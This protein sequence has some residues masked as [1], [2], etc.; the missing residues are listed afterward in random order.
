MTVV[1]IPLEEYQTMQE[2]LNLL[3]NSELLTRMNRLVDMLFQE[4]YGLF[5]KDYTKDLTEY[6]INNAWKQE[7][8]N[9]W[10]EL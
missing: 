9:A 6:A 7:D 3:R 1:N 8:T 10:D 2:E 4:K 5:M